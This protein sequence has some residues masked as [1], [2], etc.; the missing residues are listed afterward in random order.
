MQDR[1][2]TNPGR[3]KITLDDGT[4][5]N[6]ILERNDD[7]LAEGTPLNKANLFDD[8]VAARY[9]VETP[10]NAFAM[11]TKVWEKVI[12]PSAN[13]SSST[14]DKGFFTNKVTVADMKSEYEPCPCVEYTSAEMVDEEDYASGQIKEILTYDGY[15]IA[16]AVEPPDIDVTVR[17]I[18]V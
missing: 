5:L 14:D 10:N 6:G 12:I 1:Q 13:W 11:L 2:P 16:R 15:I 4:V 8:N 7:P 18:G 17:F 9:G 3:I